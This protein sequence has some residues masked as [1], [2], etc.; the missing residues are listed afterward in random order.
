MLLRKKYWSGT[1]FFGIDRKDVHRIIN[2]IQPMDSDKNNRAENSNFAED[3]DGD[4]RVDS[5]DNGGDRVG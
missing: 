1:K 3:S 4:D 2:D 5:S